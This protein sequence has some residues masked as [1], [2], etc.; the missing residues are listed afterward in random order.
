MSSAEP[1][2]CPT[3]HAF[4]SRHMKE[5]SDRATVDYYRCEQCGHVWATEKGRATLVTHIPSQRKNR[6]LRAF[7]SRAVCRSE[8]VCPLPTD[9][10]RRR[11]VAATI[12]LGSRLTL[13]LNSGDG[14]AVRRL[15]VKIRAH[16]ADI[17]S[18]R[19]RLGR[20]G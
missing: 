4:T 3:C 10:E 8:R 12:A 11:L 14:V 2:S 5:I 13:L 7:D 17:R 19:M 1:L 16:W 6:P 15:G 18:Y 20:A 9:H